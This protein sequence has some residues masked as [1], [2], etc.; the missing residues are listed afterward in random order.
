M[1]ISRKENKQQSSAS[2]KISLHLICGKISRISW[3]WFKQNVTVK[4]TSF[5]LPLN[6]MTSDQEPSCW[7]Y[8]INRK[9]RENKS[10]MLLML[11]ATTA[12]LKG[13]QSTGS[14]E[15]VGLWVSHWQLHL[16]RLLGSD[17][18]ESQITTCCEAPALKTTQHSGKANVLLLWGRNWQVALSPETNKDLTALWIRS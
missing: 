2:V 8:A 7:T 10:N 5:L 14:F 18:W 13:R 12:Q 15:G 4:S 9:I 17:K 16:H 3:K 6:C 11:K 1:Q